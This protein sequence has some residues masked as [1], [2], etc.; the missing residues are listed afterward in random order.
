M[1]TPKLHMTKSAA[2]LGPTGFTETWTLRYA[3]GP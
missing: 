3:R 1:T 2:V